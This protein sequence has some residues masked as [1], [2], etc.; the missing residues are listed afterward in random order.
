[1]AEGRRFTSQVIN[2]THKLGD[3]FDI[4]TVFMFSMFS[5]YFEINT[6]Y[7]EAE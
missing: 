5:M 6:L 3:C 4:F 1:M 7:H 2:V